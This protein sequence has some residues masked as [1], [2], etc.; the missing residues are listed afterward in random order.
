MTV[1]RQ[2]L[3]LVPTLARHQE[4]FAKSIG[5][6]GEVVDLSE[7]R[8]RLVTVH[9]R[10]AALAINAGA[11]GAKDDIP[12]PS[13]TSTGARSVGEELNAGERLTVRL[14]HTNCVWRIVAE[15]S[16]SRV[17]FAVAD[18]EETREALPW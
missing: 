16:G 9:C 14:D 17:S 11:V 15:A 1:L 18:N 10:T 6:G 13:L 4:T 2:L 7:F 8:G 12:T 5:T 3:A